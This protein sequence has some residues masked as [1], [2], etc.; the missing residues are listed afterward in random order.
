MELA[1][2]MSDTFFGVVVVFLSVLAS[3]YYFGVYRDVF[4]DFFGTKPNYDERAAELL[5]SFIEESENVD[6]KKGIEPEQNSL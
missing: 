2:F 4:T 3:L 1:M 6:S 5:N